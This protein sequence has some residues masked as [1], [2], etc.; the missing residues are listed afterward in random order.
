MAGGGVTRVTIDSRGSRLR[1]GATAAGIALVFLIGGLS[2]LFGP[3][4]V[5]G[6]SRDP[7]GF[8]RGGGVVGIGIACWLGAVASRLAREPYAVEIRPSGEVATVGA[9]RRTIVPAGEIHA[10]EW[11]S[12]RQ[13]LTIAHG[14]GAT[15]LCP[16]TDPAEFIAAVET[17]NPSLVILRR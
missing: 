15:S 2:S 17:L 11:R 3:M 13:M 4:E 5:N 9:F 6:E 14:S 10:L 12:N 1:C 16:V 8:E 7:I